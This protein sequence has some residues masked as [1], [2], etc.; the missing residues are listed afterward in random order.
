MTPATRKAIRASTAA[1]MLEVTPM[2]VKRWLA[3]GLLEGFTTPTGQY[4]I[5]LDSVER[6]T[7]GTDMDTTPGY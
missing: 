3:R 5:Y 1:K 2:T 4:R 7:Q 6:H